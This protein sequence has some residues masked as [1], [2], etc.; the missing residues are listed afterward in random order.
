MLRTSASVGGS[1]WSVEQVRAVCGLPLGSTEF[2]RP[3]AMA[4]LLGDVWQ[5][6]EP[7]WAA[8][9]TDPRVKLHLYGKA[10]P[11]PGRKMGHITATAETPSAAV[12]AVGL[13]RGDAPCPGSLPGTGRAETRYLKYLSFTGQIELEWGMRAEMDNMIGD[14]SGAHACLSDPAAHLHLYGKDEAREGRKMG[15]V[16]RITG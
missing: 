15:H 5:N 9:L 1:V 7:N 3:A 12:E 11:K 16:N 10:E 8:A 6:G 13:R 2:F 14:I 4:N